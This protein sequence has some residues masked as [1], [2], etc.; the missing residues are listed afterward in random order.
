MAM[1]APNIAIVASPRVIAEEGPTMR[2]AVAALIAEGA[3][4]FLFEPTAP[5]DPDDTDVSPER[6]QR[7][8]EVPRRSTYDAHVRFWMR[9]GR[10]ERMAEACERFAPDLIWSS[11]A[12]AWSVALALGDAIDRPV[13]LGFRRI[14]DLRETV[15]AQRDDRAVAFVA[16][17]KSLATEAMKHVPESLVRAV[18][19]GVRL[20]DDVEGSGGRMASLAQGEGGGSRDAPV[21]AILLESG[22]SPATQSALRACRAAR[23]R[24]PQ[25]ELLLECDSG[26]QGAAWR[27]ARSLGLLEHTTAVTR[28]PLTAAAV[29]ACSLLLCPEPAGG[30]RVETLSALGRGVPVI[31]AADPYSDALIDGET[32]VVVPSGT[33]ERSG[34][35]VV[36]RHPDRLWSDAVA[37]AL[38]HPEAAR[39]LARRGSDY[40]RANHRSS[41]TAETWIRVASELVSGG[42]LRFSP[43]AR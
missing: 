27:C 3:H 14:E 2:R 30:P 1:A 26:R 36:D 37:A 21:A 41:L 5:S 38:A 31:A 10:T 15:W 16:P 19:L 40:V 13:A 11:G 33:T 25:L 34:D 22:D 24:L 28:G 6:L 12:D 42:P 32:A 35:R 4:V 8:F 39:S 7:A 9:R 23:E 29:D 43:Q 18:P 20:P 17:C